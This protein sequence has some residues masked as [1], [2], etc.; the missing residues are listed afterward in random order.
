MKIPP[1]ARGWEKRA[2][3]IAAMLLFSREHLGSRIPKADHSGCASTRGAWDVCWERG[4]LV[5][6]ACHPAPTSAPTLRF[7][8]E[9]WIVTKCH[10][11]SSVP[12]VTQN[13]TAPKLDWCNPLP[14]LCAQA[15]GLPRGVREPWA[16]NCNW[17]HLNIQLQSTQRNSSYISTI[18]SKFNN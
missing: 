5:T 1:R 14:H 9:R 18:Q 6:Q 8:D 15:S 16:I 12:G 3:P 7:P 2:L 4:R 13:D 17:R 11:N 10:R